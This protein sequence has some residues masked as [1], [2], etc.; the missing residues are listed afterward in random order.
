MQR[1]KFLD[2]P[3][4]KLILF[5]GKGGSGKTISSA[6]TAL[7]LSKIR[8]EKKI[9]IISIDPA[10]SLGDS[11]DIIIGNKITHIVGKSGVMR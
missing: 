5:G 6:A 9:L 7:H 3:G 1:A 10:H 11:L 4:L 2:N 8:P